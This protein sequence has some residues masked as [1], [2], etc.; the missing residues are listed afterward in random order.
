MRPISKSGVLLGC[1]AW[2]LSACAQSQI[3]RDIDERLRQATDGSGSAAAG[4]ATSGVSAKRRIDEA[5]SLTQEQ[6]AKLQ[7]LRERTSGSMQQ[8]RS[9]TSALRS[10]LVEE[11][12]AGSERYNESRVQAIQ[13]RIEALEHKQTATL[14]ESVQEANRILGR[15]AQSHA[16]ILQEMI[17]PLRGWGWN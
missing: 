4:S 8:M 10:M 15:N 12:L 9:Q 3:S 11:V 7:A 1:A 14:F 6:K 5:T 2:L 16:K 13:T 17:D